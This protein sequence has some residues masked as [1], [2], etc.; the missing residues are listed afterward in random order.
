MSEEKKSCGCKRRKWLIPLIAAA[1]LLAAGLAVVLLG[2]FGAK[3]LYWNVD[4][5][6]YSREDREPDAN[7]IY[8]VQVAQDGQVLQ[9]PVKD[10]RL[11]R[12]MDNRNVMHLELDRDGYVT[13]VS[14][15]ENLTPVARKLY[16]KHADGKTVQANGSMALNGKDYTLQLTDKTKIYDVMLGSPTLGEKRSAETLAFSDA[17][18][19]YTDDAG[20]VSHVFLTAHS[21]SS[22]IYWRTVRMYNNGAK[23]TIR[24]PDAEGAYSIEFACNGKLETLKCRDEALVTQI[25]KAADSEAAFCFFFDKEGYISE[26]RDIRVGAHG[27]QVCS[28]YVVRSAEGKSF[29]AVNPESTMVKFEATLPQE[30]GIYEVSPAAIRDGQ[31][32]R[33]VDALQEGDRIFLWADADGTPLTVYV[34]RRKVDVPVFRLYPTTFYDSANKQTT[35]TPDGEGWYYIELIRAGEPGTKIYRTQDKA[36]VNFLDSQTNTKLVGLRLDGD[37]I[38]QVYSSSSVYGGGVV[39]KGRYVDQV[40][41]CMMNVRRN[42]RSGASVS[43]IMTPECKVYDVSGYGPLGAE[44]QL[45]PGDVVESQCNLFGQIEAVFIT[46]RR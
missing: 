36:L 28:G 29:V 44:T 42:G 7:G 21:G 5:L 40:V 22:N 12:A 19:A 43:M 2:G 1:V 6:Q 30:C 10:Q 31:I 24:V 26:V 32:G 17:F 27:V 35:R 41:G 18:V 15:P 8:W 14:D 33:Q 38:T 3:K 45:R 16:I 39:N 34:Q 4:R 25:D 20:Q 37:V 9:L 23:K 11:V 46:S 13:A